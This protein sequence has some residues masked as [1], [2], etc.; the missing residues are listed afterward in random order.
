M[1]LIQYSEPLGNL[2]SQDKEEQ[3]MSSTSME[4]DAD[5][6]EMLANAPS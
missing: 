3:E 5:D 2:V 1:L 6:S 4:V